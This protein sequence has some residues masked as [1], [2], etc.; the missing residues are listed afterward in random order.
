MQAASVLPSLAASA[1]PSDIAPAPTTSEPAA[2]S[3]QRAA[4]L[5]TSAPK[6]QAHAR[7]PRAEAARQTAHGS[8]GYAVQLSGEPTEADGRAAAKRLSAK[9]SG[10]L[11]GRHAVP[12]KAKIGSRTVWRVRVGHLSEEKAKSMCAAV[13]SAGGSCFIARD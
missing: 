9:Y 4:A 1:P 8:G 11:E 7:P 5:T 3:T 12:V 2:K 13:K 10:A 6:P